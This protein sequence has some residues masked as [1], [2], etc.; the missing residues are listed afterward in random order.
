M[1]PAYSKWAGPWRRNTS[2]GRENGAL[3]G[4]A[5]SVAGGRSTDMGT[6]AP[7][8]WKLRVPSA[9]AEAR[10]LERSKH[11]CAKPD[12]IWTRSTRRHSGTRQRGLPLG[13]GHQAKPAKR[14]A[15]EA[16]SW[17]E[18]VEVP[19][20]TACP[21][22]PG[23]GA[24]QGGLHRAREAASSRPSELHVQVVRTGA[25]LGVTQSMIR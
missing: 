4:V 21:P 12:S 16:R 18:D 10:Y 5:V 7:A 22:C 14:S 1:G 9:F 8:A 17:P 11:R 13:G 20:L 25:A 19:A 15:G 24:C 23:I 2:T 3:V 6:L